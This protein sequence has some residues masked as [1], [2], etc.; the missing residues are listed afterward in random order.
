MSGVEVVPAP[1]S[2]LVEFSYAALDPSAEAVVRDA[3]EII[4]GVQKAYTSEVARQL[5]RAKN[6]LPHGAFELWVRDV[7]DIKLRTARYHLE[8]ARWLDDKPAT[9]ADLPPTVVHA[10]ADRRTPSEI[11]SG[12]VADALAG[13]ALDAGSIR[14][15]LA[16]A[17][18]ERRE[19]KAAQK[20]SPKLT[21]AEM[22]VRRTRQAERYAAERV[23]VAAKAEAE[24]EQAEREL[25]LLPLAQMVA[26]LGADTV[27]ALLALLPLYQDRETFTALLREV[28]P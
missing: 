22:R 18:A 28:A 24:Q 26:G 17:G 27:A 8:N 21:A 25:R 2:G 16:V 13:A 12:V 6:A 10:L 20:R 9:L 1:S 15:K 14:A 4:H 11:V 5:L 3:A 23:Q 19:L 7:L